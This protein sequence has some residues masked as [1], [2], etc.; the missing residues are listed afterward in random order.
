MKLKRFN[1]AFVSGESPQERSIDL[2]GP[3]GN[4]YAI[5][6]MARNLCSQL[7][8][9]DPEKYNWDKINKEMTSGE[10]NNLVNTFGEY[11]GDYVTIYNAEVLDESLA[12]DLIIK[13]YKSMKNIISFDDYIKKK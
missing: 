7:E 5:L 11:F 10:Y 4:A 13:E 6:G 9:L 2:R 8:E 3:S 12:D 1:E